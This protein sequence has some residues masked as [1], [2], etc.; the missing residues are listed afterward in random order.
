MTTLLNLLAIPVFVVQ[1]PRL[2]LA[3][4]TGRV[5]SQIYWGTCAWL[6]RRAK[7]RGVGDGRE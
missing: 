1:R 7:A 2:A 3:R 5:R 4:L 6:S